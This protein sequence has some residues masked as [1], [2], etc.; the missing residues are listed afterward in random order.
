MHF[1]PNEKL[2]RNDLGCDNCAVWEAS[3]NISSDNNLSCW[4]K[5]NV[6]QNLVVL[7]S[8]NTIIEFS[9]RLI[10]SLK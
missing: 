8:K 9:D 4:I 1:T 7:L 3:T 6:R 10:E 5:S 2:P